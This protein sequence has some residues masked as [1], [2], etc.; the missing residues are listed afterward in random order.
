MY[1]DKKIEYDL[2]YWN[3]VSFNA[4]IKGHTHIIEY[5]KQHK[6][7]KFSLKNYCNYD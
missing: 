1:N 2:D 5:T 6:F 3:E 7:T 4:R